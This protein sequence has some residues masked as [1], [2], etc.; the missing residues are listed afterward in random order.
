VVNDLFSQKVSSLIALNWK[1]KSDISSYPIENQS[2]CVMEVDV[3]GCKKMS[4]L[5]FYQ[6]GD[7]VDYIECDGTTESSEEKQVWTTQETNK[8]IC[9]VRENEESI[10]L[11]MDNK[12][13]DST[14]EQIN[15]GENDD[16][17]D[18]HKKL[19]YLQR[20]LDVHPKNVIRIFYGRLMVSNC[21]QF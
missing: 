16:D 18:K 19:H 3:S 17:Q 11:I 10:S 5:Q 20:K 1:E 7:S 12:R 14:C 2:P 13:I 21:L 6:N 15:L 8:N 9:S 4:R